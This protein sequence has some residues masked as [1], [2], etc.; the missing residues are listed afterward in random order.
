MLI[1]W[2]C[3][4]WRHT[5]FGSFK[6]PSES[7]AESEAESD[8]ERE[9][10]SGAESEAETEASV[11]TKAEPLRNGPFTRFNDSMKLDEL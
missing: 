3:L 2:H 11:E 6:L 1:S 7:D 4:F 8:A 5:P 9:A 10:E